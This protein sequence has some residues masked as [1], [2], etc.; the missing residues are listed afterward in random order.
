[1]LV[2]LAVVCAWL[3]FRWLTHGVG[4]GIRGFVDVGMSALDEAARRYADVNWVLNYDATGKSF[5]VRP[6]DASGAKTHVSEA[7]LGDYLRKLVPKPV[8]LAVIYKGK[9]FPAAAAMADFERRMR[10]MMAPTGAEVFFLVTD[11]SPS[12]IE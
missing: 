6:G 11:E 12:R 4:H 7:E 3:A 10:E 1:M 5:A 8:K 9:D 2:A